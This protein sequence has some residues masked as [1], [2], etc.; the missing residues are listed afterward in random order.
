V[1]GM[2]IVWCLANAV[3]G[4]SGLTPGAAGLP[5]AWEAHIIGYAAGLLLITP[6]AWLSGTHAAITD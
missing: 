1:I 3:L 2:T 5:V 6:F 4:L